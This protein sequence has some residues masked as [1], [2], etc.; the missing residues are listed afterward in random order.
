MKVLAV[1]PLLQRAEGERDCQ[2]AVASEDAT[3]FGLVAIRRIGSC[4][5]STDQPSSQG[6]ALKTVTYRRAS[7][8]KSRS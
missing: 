4:A 1:G 7:S 6:G 5:V 3:E 8:G 2:V